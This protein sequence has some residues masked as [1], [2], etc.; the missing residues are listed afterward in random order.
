MT[1]TGE[2]YFLGSNYLAKGSAPDRPLEIMDQGFQKIDFPTVSEFGLFFHGTTV[3]YYYNSQLRKKGAHNPAP[4]ELD[5]SPLVKAYSIS[6]AMVD[7]EGILWIGSGRGMVNLNSLL[8]LNYN[9]FN[10]G[11]L[12]EEISAIAQVGKDA[13]LFGFNNG[14]Q[15]FS[16]KQFIWILSQSETHPKEL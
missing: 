5:I 8:F 1:E 11:L 6:S 7:R 4:L 16:P 15:H 2:Y 14:I 3:F 12:S 10:T 9:S 13:F